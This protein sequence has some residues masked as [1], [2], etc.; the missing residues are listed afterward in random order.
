MP[1]ARVFANG[2]VCVHVRNPVVK[3]GEHDSGGFSQLGEGREVN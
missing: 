1:S 2:C 3:F